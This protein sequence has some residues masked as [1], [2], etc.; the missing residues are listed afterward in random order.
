MT[1]LATTSRSPLFVRIVAT[2]ALALTANF[3]AAFFAAPAQ[4]RY[5]SIVLDFETGKVLSEQGADERRHPAS[6]TKMMTLYLIFEALDQKQITLD[7]RWNV[8]AHAAGQAPTKLGL[9]EGDRIRV[10]D[11]ILG[12]VTR[13]ANDAAVVAAEGLGGSEPK[14]AELMTRRARQI[15]MGSTM[16]VNA[17]GLPADAQ[18]TTARDM[19]T[20]GRELIRRFPHHYHYFSTAEFVYE[21]RTFPNHNRLMRWYDGA[22]GIKTGYIRASGFNLVASAMRDGRRI[23]GA[24]IGGP[25]PT[26]RDQY[27]GKLLDAGFTHSPDLPAVRVAQA[28]SPAKT[29]KASKGKTVKVADAKSGTREVGGKAIHKAEPAEWA[30]QV[31]AFNQ[32][33]Q[34]RKAAEE[35]VRIAGPVAASAEIQILGPASRARSAAS[36]R[37]RLTNLTQAQARAACRVLDAKDMD[38]MIVGPGSDKRANR[39][40]ASAG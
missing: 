27:M 21:G 5:A 32:R 30:V 38:C 31:G 8:S 39:S 40:V 23:V 16:F 2:I 3:V 13:S 14:F 7:T 1:A 20:L 36:H 35:A 4:A 15:G 11:V 9:E 6:L 26:E 25:N 18:V 33:G 37:A 29:A 22:D 12:L 19:A 17:S 24:V 34:A 10:R 28:K